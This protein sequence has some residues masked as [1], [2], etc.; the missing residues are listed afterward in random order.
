[1]LDMNYQVP[2]TT[3][4]SKITIIDLSSLTHCSVTLS[5][6]LIVLGIRSLLRPVESYRKIPVRQ[7]TTTFFIAAPVQHECMIVA[8]IPME[9]LRR[10]QKHRDE[11]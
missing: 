2:Y 6:T 3:S 1:M 8:D 9:Y 11:L 10:E 7:N 5:R 4:V